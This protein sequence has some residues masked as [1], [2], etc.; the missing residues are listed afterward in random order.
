LASSA[1]TDDGRMALV[2]HIKE[3][4]RRLLI[5]A[6][7]FVVAVAV[8][9]ALWH[10]LYVFLRA[11]YCDAF[12]KVKGNDCSLFVSGIFE[13]FNVRM[14]VAFI[15][16]AVASSP[17]WLYQLGAFITPAL[18]KK[19]R[20]YAGGFLVAALL[21]FAAGTT[22]AYVSLSHGIKILLHVAG[23]GVTNITGLRDYLSFATLMLV[24]FGIAFEF[25]VLVVF[26]N[27]V[28][29]LSAERMRH[30]RRGMCFALFAAAAVLTPST[31]PFTF[32][33][34]GVPLYLMYEICIVIARLRERGAR[35]R[36]AVEA[37]EEIP[38]DQP[39]DVDTTLSQI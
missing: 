36:A 27:V 38:D 31:D 8:A 26:L 1:R 39:S 29:L 2:E 35:K 3:L 30:W 21:L 10:P 28:G 13:Q 20:K 9:Y 11:P 33:V 32:I 22:V 19:E 25:P 12:P 17:I 34:L 14:K 24:L 4:R 6:A 16:G 5:S 23:P 15:G 37:L 7:A 18:H